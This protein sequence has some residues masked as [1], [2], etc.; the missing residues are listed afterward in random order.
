MAKAVAH[1]KRKFSQRQVIAHNSVCLKNTKFSPPRAMRVLQF[2]LRILHRRIAKT[3]EP[4]NLCS[5]YTAMKAGDAKVPG[6]SARFTLSALG[7]GPG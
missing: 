4:R 7:R 5:Y 6:R 1:A 3:D 2:Y